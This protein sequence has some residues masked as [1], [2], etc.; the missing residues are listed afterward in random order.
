MD[1]RKNRPHSS[2]F[3]IGYGD[4]QPGNIPSG[5]HVRIGD[6]AAAWTSKAPAVSLTNTLAHVTRFAG[7][8]RLDYDERDSSEPGLVVKKRTK[9]EK[10]PSVVSSSLGLPDSRSLPDAGQLLNSNALILAKRL[11][12][13]PLADC[14]IGDGGESLFSALKPFQE[15]PAPVRAFALN[16][17]P[18][19]EVFV[20]YLVKLLRAVLSPI[21]KGSNLV[22]AKI[23]AN[24]FFHIFDRFFW[25]LYCLEEIPF[26]FF[27]HQIGLAF[28]IRQKPFVV[29]HKRYLDSTVDSPE[30]SN[31]A[32]V[33][34][35][36]RVV[37]NSSKG[38]EGTFALPVELIGVDDLTD[39]TNK[40]LGGEPRGLLKRVVHKVVDLE[41]VPH[42]VL[43]DYFGNIVTRS[44]GFFQRGKQRLPLLVY[45]KKLDLEGKFHTFSIAQTLEEV[46]YFLGQ[47]LL[48]AA[49][50]GVSAPRG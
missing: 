37:G 40:H 23:H 14:M 26:P 21:G 46:K 9:L 7:V 47:A 19:L 35:D 22:H 11:L 36:A 20:S 29:T 48:P 27:R 50:N 43:P 4:P 31:H 3:G 44:V 17:A 8:A 41:L 30:G 6:V 39:A 49:S 33:G 5:I 12:D 34:E 2:L 10:G 18:G 32:S 42:F 45:W 1:L 15:L 24:K 16:G 28:D 38:S 25:N 13:Y